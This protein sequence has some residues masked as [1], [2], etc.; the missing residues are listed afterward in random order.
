MQLPARL[1]GYVTAFR[2]LRPHRLL[3]VSAMPA[4][5]VLNESIS[6][7]R[8]MPVPLSSTSTGSTS[9]NADF[10]PLKPQDLPLML[11]AGIIKEAHLQAAL[12]QQHTQ[13]FTACLQ[14]QLLMMLL[15]WQAA[16]ATAPTPP[17]WQQGFSASGTQLIPNTQTGQH[18]STFVISCNSPVLKLSLVLALCMSFLCALRPW[19]GSLLQPA[20]TSLLLP[21]THMGSHG[22]QPFVIGGVGLGSAACPPA[23]SG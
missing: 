11:A 13:A 22:P 4:D 17:T 18:H 9:V 7:Y 20:T 6:F 14:S 5:H 3:P 15:L 8:Q 1:S 23:G 10:R 19:R 21:C 2:A 12:Q 16:A